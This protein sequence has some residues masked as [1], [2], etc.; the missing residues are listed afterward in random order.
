MRLDRFSLERGRGS[1]RDLECGKFVVVVGVHS[2]DEGTSKDGAES[3]ILRHGFERGK[4]SRVLVDH[5]H[6]EETG[7]VVVVGVV[8]VG[9]FSAATLN[10]VAEL[11]VIA[12]F[13]EILRH[14]NHVAECL[15]VH[16]H[17]CSG[18]VK[19]QAKGVTLTFSRTT[20]VGDGDHVSDVEQSAL[21]VVGRA[22]LDLHVFHPFVFCGSCHMC[23]PAQRNAELFKYFVLRLVCGSREIAGKE[24]G[25]E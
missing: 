12:G 6:V 4:E 13:G 9:S 3:F 22:N 24:M 19:S 7:E 25:R 21:F 1:R 5:G 11:D 2:F 16:L 20:I 18:G 17:R 23:K 15:R 14:A 8:P 10:Q